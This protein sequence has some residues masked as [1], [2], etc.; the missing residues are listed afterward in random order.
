MHIFITQDTITMG[1]SAAD[2]ITTPRRDG[3]ILELNDLMRKNPDTSI[4]IDYGDYSMC[5][6]HSF[7]LDIFNRK[8]ADEIHES[9]ERDDND[10]A[11]VSLTEMSG[12]DFSLMQA[13]DCFIAA[14]DKITSGT[15]A[16]GIEMPNSEAHRIWR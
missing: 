4:T 1:E 8:T 10:K 9:G 2:E 12:K 6:T 3:S 5:I 7:T 13:E 15:R 14:I 16:Y 11:G